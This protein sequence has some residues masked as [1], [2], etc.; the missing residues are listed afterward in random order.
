MELGKVMDYQVA[1]WVSMIQQGLRYV[2]NLS[3]FHQQL[4][5]DFM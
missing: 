5:K 3:Y 1:V 2:N 4:P